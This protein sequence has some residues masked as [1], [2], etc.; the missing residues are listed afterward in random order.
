[1]NNQMPKALIS[2]V[3]NQSTQIAAQNTATA[4]KFQD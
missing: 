1:M 4:R 3:K 2:E